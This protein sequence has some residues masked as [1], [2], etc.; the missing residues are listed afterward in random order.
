MEVHFQSMEE[1]RKM[2]FR[3]AVRVFGRVIK[4][5]KQAVS[6]SICPITVNKLPL[7]SI[8]KKSDEQDQVNNADSAI[9]FLINY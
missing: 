8:P 1:I 6:Y 4:L 7:L 2:L 3:I 9:I 5:I